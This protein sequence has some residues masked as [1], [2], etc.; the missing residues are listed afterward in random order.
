MGEVNIR[1][2]VRR[3]MLDQIAGENFRDEHSEIVTHLNRTN[4]KALVGIQRKDGI[5]TIVGKENIYY[6]TVAGVEGSIPNKAFLDMLRENVHK[7]GKTAQFEFIKVNDTDFVW[8][9]NGQTMSALW[10]ILKVLVANER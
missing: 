2:R 8:L 7:L 1:A 6:S 10:D 4:K 9:F 3:N 5:Y